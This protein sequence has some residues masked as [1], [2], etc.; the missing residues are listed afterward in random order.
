MARY[1]DFNDMSVG[2]K[3]G[4]PSD[5]ILPVLAAAEYAGADMHSTIAGIVLAYEVQDRVGD[6]CADLIDSGWDYVLYAA[7]ASAAGAGR[8]MALSKEQM[9]NA[10]A[11][12][13]VPNAAMFQTRVGQL[14]MWKGCAAANAARNGVFAALMA[15]RG[16]TGP[17]QAFEGS[18][19]FNKQFG[20]T[21]TLP[22][23][24]GATLRLLLSRVDLRPSLAIMRPSAVLRLRWSF[25]KCS[26]ETW[27]R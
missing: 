11:L 13:V 12:A 5:N 15:R 2:R 22:T 1:S 16:L 8:A 21:L 27:A 25:T 19:G 4:H 6:V 18:C 17:E 10:L 26:R 14:S 7:L 20:I 9:A 23:F 24:A 3:A